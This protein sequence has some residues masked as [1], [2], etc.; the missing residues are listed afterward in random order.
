MS[1]K[2]AILWSTYSTLSGYVILSVFNCHH[3]SP[4]AIFLLLGFVSGYTNKDIFSL[5]F[6]SKL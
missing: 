3:I 2:N 4:H 6:P 1:I 5:V